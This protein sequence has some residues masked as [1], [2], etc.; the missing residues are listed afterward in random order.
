M[1][2]PSLLAGLMLLCAAH[3]A[4]AA[5]WR[6]KVDGELLELANANPSTEFMVELEARADLAPAKALSARTD[7]GAAVVSAL[8]TTAQHS[9]RELLA[10]LDRRGL[11]Y[12]TYWIANAVHLKGS[13]ADIQ[14]IAALPS[15]RHLHWIKAM[16]A[17]APVK[18]GTQPK[19][20]AVPKLGIEPSLALLHV[21]EVWDL[22]FKGQGVV[23]GDHDIGVEWE[24]PALK[25]HYRGWDESTQ[26]ANHDYNWLN[27]FGALDPFCTDTAVP[28]DSNG[29]G[30]HTTG[31]MVG[32]DGA[33]M[34]IGMAPQAE[35]MA[36]RS[37]LDPFVGLGTVPTYLDCM[38]WMIAPYPTGDSTAADPAMAPDVVNNS[39]GCVE[40]CAPPLLQS[41]NE[42]TKAAGIVQVVSAGN[43]GDTCGTI[44][45]PLAVYESSFTVGATDNNDEMASFS[46]R[47]PVLTDLS[48]R[49]K[50]DVVAP[51]VNTLSSVLDGEYDE[52]SGTSMAGPHVA[53][54]VA[55]LMSA[56]PRLIGRVDDIQD[57]IKYTA[58]PISSDQA[59]GGTS[60]LDIPNSVFGYGRIDALAAVQGRPTLELDLSGSGS[61]DR[62]AYQAIVSLPE[63]AAI[64][65]TGVMLTV[66][67]PDGTQL[68][69]GSEA[70]ATED[71]GA[72]SFVH[73]SLE[74]GTNWTVDL[75]LDTPANADILSKTE[76]DQVSPVTG[77][78]V[79]AESV[80]G[81]GT[82][83]S[84]GGGAFGAFSLF[85]LLGL[86]L[87]RQRRTAAR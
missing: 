67:L 15:V 54:L 69:S 42:A 77:P 10:E 22:G 33:G 86:L 23:V 82:G 27:A 39:W 53:G 70:P 35:W 65:A 8:K 78:V 64:P 52:Y 58:V 29:H 75:M 80:G 84:S 63:G 12:R 73:E 20:R 81:S 1:N 51:G 28:C 36:C 47:G 61:A 71:G 7:R 60:Q 87:A 38:E 34:Q 41:V 50:P 45:F 11:D 48:L 46:S 59:C 31:T 4:T 13:L 18:A 3:I 19:A 21:P 66:E 72:L 74:P 26:T 85:A 9:Q 24:H 17:P 40:A 32:D 49:I 62:F 44:A 55:L 30:T 79:S 14:A 2:Q 25:S 43:D 5:D 68:I 6:N 37:L 83:A 57:I 56:E 76:A 16:P